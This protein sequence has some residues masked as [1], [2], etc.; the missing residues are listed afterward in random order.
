MIAQTPVTSTNAQHHSDTMLQLAA[1]TD[2]LTSFAGC[3]W[4]VKRNYAAFV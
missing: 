1:Y 2:V 4:T 3:G